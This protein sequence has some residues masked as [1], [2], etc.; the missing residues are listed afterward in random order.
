MR[1]KAN[2]IMEVIWLL[3]FLL[4]LGISISQTI[5][6]GFKQSLLFYG[7]TIL[8]MLMFLFRRF[9]RKNQAKNKTN[10]S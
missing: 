8:A 7:I 2:S 4:C 6:L 9:M 1:L 5:Q 3:V 10:N